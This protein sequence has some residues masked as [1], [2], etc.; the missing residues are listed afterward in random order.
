MI[1]NK[2]TTKTIA[3]QLH[4]LLHPNDD[5]GMALPHEEHPPQPNGLQLAKLQ[6]QF[7][8]IP[9]SSTYYS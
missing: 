4:P 6:P 3:N 7:I 8:L 1:N 2:N 9:P 5:K